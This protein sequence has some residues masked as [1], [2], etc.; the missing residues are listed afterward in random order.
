M[1]LDR[2]RFPRVPCITRAREL[3]KDGHR[4]ARLTDIS[5]GGVFIQRLSD[6]DLNVGDLVRLQ[7]ELPRQLGV[8]EGLCEVVADSRDIFYE[9]GAARFRMLRPGDRDRIRRYISEVQREAA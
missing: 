5:E 4:P 8:I 2:R 3:R 6:H 7:F 9:A 1:L